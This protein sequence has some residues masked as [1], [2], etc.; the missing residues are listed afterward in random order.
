[1]DCQICYNP[2][3]KCLP[4]NFYFP[5]LRVKSNENILIATN[6]NIIPYSRLWS[7]NRWTDIVMSY[8]QIV[9][10]QWRYDRLNIL[11]HKDYGN[12]DDKIAWK[13]IT[14][15]WDIPGY[16]THLEKYNGEYIIEG[17]TSLINLD[18]NSIESMYG[19]K[20]DKNIK[21]N[22]NSFL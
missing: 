9:D 22:L 7:M 5:P 20:C 4:G 19:Y 17:T 15:L 8:G 16:Y 21:L 13:T 1:M 18:K 6:H 2:I 12:I 3:K 10:T 14:Y 11:L